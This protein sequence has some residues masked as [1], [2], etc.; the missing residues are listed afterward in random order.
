MNIEKVN[1][2][3]ILE[4]VNKISK[5]LSENNKFVGSHFRKKR[6]D[7]KVRDIQYDFC[8]IPKNNQYKI[9]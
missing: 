2:K 7:V 1:C 8:I 4:F 5:L 9:R 3:N 6:K